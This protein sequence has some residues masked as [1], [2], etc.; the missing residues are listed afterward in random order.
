MA[1]HYTP[2]SGQFG[3]AMAYVRLG[4]GPKSLLYIPGGPGNDLPEGTPLRM[5]QPMLRPLADDG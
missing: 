2:Q 5:L 1:Q 4:D 3:N